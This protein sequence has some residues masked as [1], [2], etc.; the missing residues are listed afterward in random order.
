ML[1]S[2]A[3]GRVVSP[4]IK[5]ILLIFVILIDIALISKYY[6]RKAKLALVLIFMITCF[7]FAIL[8]SAFDVLL[9]WQNLLGQN[10]FLGMGL[11]FLMSG[12]GIVFYLYQIVE[13]FYSKD[14][15]DSKYKIIFS[16]ISIGLVGLTGISLILR[17]NRNPAAFYFVAGYF[18]LLLLVI[19]LMI[20]NA[21]QIAGRVPEKEYKQRFHFMGWSALMLL[22]M[23]IFFIIDSLYEEFTVYSLIGWTCVALTLYFVYRGYI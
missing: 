22:L 2:D 8:F 10:T 19:V 12:L 18:V 23:M 5:I 4:T 14:H 9:N 17:I 7:A 13:V 1:L 15:W 11:A 6:H 3:V 21:F 16:L 20:K